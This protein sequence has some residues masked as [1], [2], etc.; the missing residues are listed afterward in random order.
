MLV[1]FPLDANAHSGATNTFSVS[2]STLPESSGTQNITITTDL[3]P[4]DGNITFDYTLSGGGSSGQATNGADMPQLN[5]TFAMGKNNTSGTISVAVVDDSLLEGDETVVFCIDTRTVVSNET[6]HSTAFTGQSFISGND[7]CWNMTIIDDDV[8]TAE[9]IS[10]S[11]SGGEALSS[12]DVIVNLSAA[13]LGTITLD[14]TLTGTAT[15]SGTDYT[16]ANGTLTIP[17]GNTSGTITIGSIVE[18]SIYEGNETVVVTLSAPSN[19]V[20]GSNQVHTYTI[21]DN[22]PAPTISVNDITVVEGDSGTTTGYATVTTATVSA[23]DITVYYT[24]NDGTATSADGDFNGSTVAT[25]ISGGSASTQ[26]PVYVFG[27]TVLEDNETFTLRL[28]GASGATVPASGQDGVVTISNDDTVSISVRDVSQPEGAGSVNVTVELSAVAGKDV[29]FNYATTNGTALAGSEYTAVTGAAT[30]SNGS[31]STVVPVTIADNSTDDAW[32]TF[33]LDIT[34]SDATVTD[35]RGDVTIIDDDGTIAI[36]DVTV[37]EG[38]GTATLTVTLTGPVQSD[39]YVD[40]TTSNGTATV[41]DDFTSTLWQSHP[42][43]P[44]FFIPLP[45][46]C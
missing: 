28:T 40:Y 39:V 46:N 26:I 8:P 22:D 24:F 3:Q 32:S 16:L 19:A 4:L 17:P 14:Y 36:D 10:T 2:T 43:R 23:T 35:G 44:S 29:V 20:L 1:L 33:Y 42:C 13:S 7:Y 34:S 25:T 37:N 21:I 45:I 27:D 12:S 38:A 5:G 41:S 30:I 11:S 18:D 6:G 15:G 9:F 31:S